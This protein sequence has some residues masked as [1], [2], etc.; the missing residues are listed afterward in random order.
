[1][2]LETSDV[3]LDSVDVGLPHVAASLFERYAAPEAAGNVS[4]PQ[5]LLAASLDP[6]SEALS[7][8]LVGIGDGD[9]AAPSRHSTCTMQC[10]DR[11]EVAS[12]IT[13]LVG[14]SLADTDCD[15]CNRK[16]AST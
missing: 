4:T 7:H 10:S 15:I 8:E 6:A 16:I 14:S 3:G 5:R 1:M 12:S 11:D 9:V 13:K 2:A